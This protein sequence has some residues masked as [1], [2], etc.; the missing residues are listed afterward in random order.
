MRLACGHARYGKRM[1]GWG[2]QASLHG[3]TRVAAVPNPAA[4]LPC[5]AFSQCSA[6]Q[7]SA[8]CPLLVPRVQPAIVYRSAVPLPPPS[9]SLPLAHHASHALPRTPNAINSC[10][11]HLTQ[12]DDGTRLLHLFPQLFVKSSW[13]VSDVWT[14]KYSKWELAHLSG[15]PGTSGQYDE[16]R[17]HYAIRWVP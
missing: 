15:D 7:L 13:H 6:F 10:A 1:V 12:V 2:H 17:Y 8:C 14:K 11:I 16:A 5:E 3:G 4:L 9:P